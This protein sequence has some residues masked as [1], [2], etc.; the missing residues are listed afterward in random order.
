MSVA[1][2]LLSLILLTAAAA[3]AL[4]GMGLHWVDRAA[5]TPEPI[6]QIIGPVTSDDPVIRAI[7][8]ELET[9]AV[10]QIPEAA[11]L[12]PGARDELAGLIGQAIGFAL[13]EESVNRAWFQSV[14]GTRIRLMNSL[15]AVRDQ[16]ADAPTVWFPLAPFVELGQARLNELAGPALQPLVAQLE[17]PGDLAV[18]LGRLDAGPAQRAAN[19]IGLAR[20]WRWYYAGAAGLAMVGLLSGSRRGRWVALLIATALGLVGLF[21]AARATEFVPVPPGDSLSGAIRARL[22]TGSTASVNAWIDTAMMVGYVALAVSVLGLIVASL[23]A[24]RR[25]DHA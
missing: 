25:R 8:T 15:D 14:D 4:V 7:A 2:S 11:D 9:A 6:R 19:I 17:V 16:G 13:G 22:V 23:A 24:R 21:A 3:V 10:Q 18:P 5:R 20:D 12:L 1:R